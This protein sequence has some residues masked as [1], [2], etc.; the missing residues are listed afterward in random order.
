MGKNLLWE[1]GTE[2]LPARFIIPA[3]ESLKILAEKKLKESLLNFE[4]IKTAGTLRRLTLFVKN[5]IRKT[6]RNR[7]RNS[8]SFSKNRN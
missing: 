4:E 7:R 3:L 2:E 8:W 6:R 1:I 5:L